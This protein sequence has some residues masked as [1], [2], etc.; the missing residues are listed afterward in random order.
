M[1]D[2]LK[3][4]PRLWIITATIIIVLIIFLPIEIPYN[5]SVQGKIIAGEEWLIHKQNDGSIVVSHKNHEAD[6]INNYTAYQIDR[7]DVFRFHLQESLAY[8]RNVTAGDTLGLVYSYS[9]YQELMR[10]EGS[11]EVARSN[12]Q[13]NLTGEKES[14]ISQAQDE[15]LLNLERANVQKKILE[16][17]SKLYQDA[18]VSS[19]EFEITRGMARISELEAKVA[20]ARLKSLQTGD[21]TE[22]I[23]MVQ[24]EIQAIADEIDVLKSKLSRF[25]LTTPLSGKIS[26]VFSPD[27]LLMVHNSERI[28]L[29]P[30][31]WTNY[32]EVSPDQS[33]KADIIPLNMSVSGKIIRISNYIDFVAGAQVFYAVGVLS[34]TD[35]NIPLNMI[36][37]CSI[38]GNPKT[39]VQYIKEFFI[40]LFT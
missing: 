33:F 28:I 1:I 8:E 31:P 29:M 2:K 14:I 39:I 27:T 22:M 38:A 9:L 23:G 5:I 13:V 6:F 17:Q 35:N 15:Y 19:E 10:L 20:D 37:S 30:V 3:K 32:T 40:I 26:T 34:G 11:L 21:K 4:N 7:G 25:A 18:L 36:T 24:N 12:L 16:R